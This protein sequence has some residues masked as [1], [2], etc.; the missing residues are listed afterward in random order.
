MLVN[1]VST[2]KFASG[3]ACSS[4]GTESDVVQT[5]WVTPAGTEMTAFDPSTV[6]VA[7]PSGLKKLQRP[8]LSEAALNSS[9]VSPTGQESV[10]RV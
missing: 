4:R 1:L 9:E 7:S 2:S 10:V 3:A 8:V 5:S 6:A